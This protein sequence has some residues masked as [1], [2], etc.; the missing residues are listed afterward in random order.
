MGDA[1]LN[2]AQL[3]LLNAAFHQGSVHAS[4]QLAKWLDRPAVLELD[5]LRVTPI[6]DATELLA[7]GD[8]PICFC[9]MRLEGEIAGQL[10]LAFDDSSGREL[11]DRVIGQPVGTTTEWSEL[12]LSAVLETTNIVG[13][14]YLNALADR[15]CDAGH[16]VSLLPT[17]P[18]FSR[19]Y[20]QSLMQFALMDQALEFNLVILAETRFEISKQP[21]RWNLLFI[22]E[23]ASLRHIAEVL[24]EGESEPAGKPES[25]S[26]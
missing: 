6:A 25:D 3:E 4:Q 24:S 10:I 9:A 7:T 16:N 14:A 12:A 23:A 11:A 17:P 26:S 20:A 19:E 13:C 2:P 1:A 15:M 18:E 21:V 22:P 5:T 8:E